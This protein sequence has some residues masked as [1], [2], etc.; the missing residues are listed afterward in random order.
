MSHKDA[1]RVQVPRA[2]PD[3]M[4]GPAIR[5]RAEEWGYTYRQAKERMIWLSKKSRRKK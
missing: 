1:N 4:D 2:L 3:W 5:A